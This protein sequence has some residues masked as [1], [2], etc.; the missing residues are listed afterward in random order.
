MLYSP[1]KRLVYLALL[2]SLSIVLTRIASITIPFEGVVTLRLGFGPLPV[3]IAGLLFGPYYGA[4]VGILGD[5]IGFNLNPMGPY[6]PQFTVIAGLHGLL[7]PL[8]M[9]LLG[10]TF[11]YPSLLSAVALTQIITALILTPYTLKTALGIPWIITMPG[12]LVS[13][14]IIIPLFALLSRKIITALNF[15]GQWK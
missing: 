9:R 15:Q 5:I 3:I 6:L 11:T 10:S 2:I 7:P 8:V 13:Q 14:V 1:T 4:I 12:R